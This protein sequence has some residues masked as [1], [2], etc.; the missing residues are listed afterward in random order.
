MPNTSS[1]SR[2]TW[3]QLNAWRQQN[4]A[5]FQTQL[6]RAQDLASVSA[7]QPLTI[8]QV[9]IPANASGTLKDFLTTQAGLA[10][11]CTLIHNQLLQAKSSGASQVEVDLMRQRASQTFQQQHAE[12]LKLQS[13]RAQALAAEAASHLQAPGPAV[14]PPNA[15]PQLKAY[16]IAQDVLA[17]D[18]VQ[19]RNQY[20]TADPSA[21]EAAMR[22]WHKQNASRIKQLRELAQ[23]LSDSVANQKGKNQ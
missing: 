16:L 22:E 6:Q 2:V 9:D 5:R 7:L 12:D 19:F 17:R 18:Q 1:S 8:E 3:E 13:Q 15:T 10:N 14:I 4:A 20:L 23:G 11:G 21:K